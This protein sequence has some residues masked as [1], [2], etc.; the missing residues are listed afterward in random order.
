MR[1][2]VV[3]SAIAFALATA[4]TAGAGGW[5]TVGFAPLPDETAAGGTWHPRITILQHGRTQL[6]GL[7]PVVTILDVDSG[8]SQAFTATS[9]AEA[10][11]YEADVVFPSSGDW[12][13]AIDST[14]GESRVSYG[15]VTIAP[16]DSG[17]GSQPL[18]ILGVLAALGALALAAAA[19]F[20]A[21]RFKKLT[22]ASG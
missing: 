12:R 6:D 14:F 5:A 8:A 18:P 2:L 15:P 19:I 22:P 13:V 11:V 17:T 20:G 10:G 7:S 1:Y 16:G 9:T 3:L 21:R 4:T